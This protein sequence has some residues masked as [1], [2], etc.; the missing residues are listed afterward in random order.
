MLENVIKEIESV[1]DI[2]VRPYGIDVIDEAVC[3]TLT[4]L[5]DDGAVATDRLEIRIITRTVAK[6]QDLRQAVVNALVTVGD[7]SK[8]SYLSCTLNGGGNLWD[9]N[10]KLSHTILYFYIT[11]KSEVIYHG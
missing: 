5:T 11:M 10:T 6:A 8:D 9:D 4:P 2:P 7:N 3:Y 1:V